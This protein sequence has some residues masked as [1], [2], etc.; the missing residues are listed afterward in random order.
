MLF[1]ITNRIGRENMKKSDKYL[2][3]ITKIKKEINN[4]WRKLH[5]YPMRR[6][7]DKKN[8]FHLQAIKNPCLFV[9]VEEI[10]KFYQSRE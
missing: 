5:G 1:G 7:R 8:L 3:I 6:H 4:N 9:E 10:D 2:D